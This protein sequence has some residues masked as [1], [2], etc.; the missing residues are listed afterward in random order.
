MLAAPLPLAPRLAY[1][2][3]QVSQAVLSE[4]AGAARATVL[5]S[6]KAFLL[7]GVFRSAAAAA[8]AWRPAPAYRWAPSSARA[9]ALCTP[10]VRRPAHRPLPL[11]YTR[12]RPGH[13]YSTRPAARS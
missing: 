3:A 9:T 8:L 12:H 1:E 2:S 10:S 4:S 5:V 7:A 6:A 11:T 13:W